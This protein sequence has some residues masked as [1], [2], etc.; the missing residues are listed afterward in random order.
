[1]PAPLK[2]ASQSYRLLEIPNH[3]TRRTILRRKAK[4][5]LGEVSFTSWQAWSDA[6]DT[7][8]DAAEILDGGQASA[9][10]RLK[11]FS[12]DAGAIMLPVLNPAKN[13]D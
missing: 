7:C 5:P 1:M 2:T 11:T 4:L 8:K 10:V 13:A 6:L 9:G 12:K 3:C